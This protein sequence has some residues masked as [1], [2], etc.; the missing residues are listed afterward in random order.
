[1]IPATA[2]AY[3]KAL[4]DAAV[5]LK[6]RIKVKAKGIPIGKSYD[7]IADEMGRMKVKP[8]R[9]PPGQTLNQQYQAKNRKRY[10]GAK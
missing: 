1:M 5:P 4:E 8:K 9:K 10:R 3:L 7:A 2:L 6:P